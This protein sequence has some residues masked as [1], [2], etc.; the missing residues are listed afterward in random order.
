MLR[1]LESA[2][3]GA[4]PGGIISL[5]DEKTPPPDAPP[6]KASRL[7]AL[8]KRQLKTRLTEFAATDTQVTVARARDEATRLL[9]VVLTQA[10]AEKLLTEFGYRASND[11][12]PFL[13]AGGELETS[14]VWTLAPVARPLTP[15][16]KAQALA[17][18]LRLLSHAF[19]EDLME[20]PL[21]KFAGLDDIA[22]EATRSFVL[23]LSA[24]VKERA[25]FGAKTILPACADTAQLVFHASLR[26]GS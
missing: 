4:S 24:A 16:E 17:D 12:E 15:T 8:Q 11:L 5:M 10:T 22:Q 18:R 21:L 23:S 25:R 9:G 6:V 14:R 13:G 19:V 20:D 2:G 26:S 3:A 1:L 7:N